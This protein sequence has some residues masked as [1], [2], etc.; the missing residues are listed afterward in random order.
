[1][2]LVIYMIKLKHY[3]D[4]NNKYIKLINLYLVHASV[5]LAITILHCFRLMYILLHN[6]LCTNF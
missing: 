5:R 2:L 3:I 4:E 6:F 1:M